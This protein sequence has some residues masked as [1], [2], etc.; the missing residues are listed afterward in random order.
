MVKRVLLLGADGFIG[1]HIAL[2]LMDMGVEL[3]CSARNVSA[4]RPL[5]SKVFQADMTNPDVDWGEAVKGCDAIVNA[6]G[7]LNGPDKAMQMVHVDT[8][9]RVYQAGIAAG[10]T[11]IVLISAVGIDADTGFGRTKTAGEEVVKKCGAA[12]VIMRPSMVLAETSYG[13][14]SL[15]RAFA[16]LPFVIPMVGS[17]MQ[18]FDPIHAK[19]LAKSVWQALNSDDLDGK[20]ISPCGPERVTQ[21]QML[22]AYRA[23][24]GRPDTRFFAMPPA[25]AK[26]AGRLGDWLKLGPISSTAVAQLQQGVDADYS[27]YN[28]QTGQRPLGFSRILASRPAGTQDLWHARLYLLR[29]LIRFGLLFMWLLS[30]IV[31]LTLPAQQFVAGLAPLGLSDTALTLLARGAGV[32]DL[33]FALGLLLAW[34]PKSLA[35]LQLLAV[36]AYTLVFGIMAP[37]LWLEPY[38]GL[39]KN[40]PVLILILVHLALAEER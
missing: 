21:K 35:V 10:V 28:R 3:V 30:G 36:G 37:A 17:G 22:Q 1:R 19:D 31:G 16:A 39:L 25:M 13:G 40:I 20:T 9:K 29:I 26:L 2:H 7:L 23:W 34:R 33:A 18:K 27:E 32:M 15:L 14:S 4:L 38:G 5:G 8:P 12:Y 11:K 6:A 24:L